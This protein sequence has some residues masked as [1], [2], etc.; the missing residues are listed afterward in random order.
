[1]TSADHRMQG[2]AWA[3]LAAA[4]A[5]AERPLAPGTA[6]GV[7]FDAIEYAA[8]EGR[9]Y[10]RGLVDACTAGA[11][12]STSVTRGTA[13]LTISSASRGC[14][15]TVA[16]GH[17]RVERALPDWRRRLGLRIAAHDVALAA[18]RALGDQDERIEQ[19]RRAVAEV[20]EGAR[21]ADAAEDE[22]TPVHRCIRH[23]ADLRFM[24][25]RARKSCNLVGRGRLTSA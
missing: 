4:A 5:A 3:R 20:L 2:R 7:L 23:Y 22:R 19:T 9:L 8:T 14:R 13:S 16:D 12:S 10:L 17:A 1:M 25:T 15:R 18:H 6:D 11:A 24:P 21:A